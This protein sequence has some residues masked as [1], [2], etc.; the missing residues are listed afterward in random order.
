MV[1]DRDNINDINMIAKCMGQRARVHLKVDTGMGRFGCSPEEAPDLA[2]FAHRLEWVELEG[3]AT[4]FPRSDEGPVGFTMHQINLFKRVISEVSERGAGYKFIHAAN[5]GALL[6]RV[7]Q[8]PC[9][10]VRTGL[11]LYGYAPS[12][13]LFDSRLRPA[14]EV[15]TRVIQV[16][17][18]RKGTPVG[19]ATPSMP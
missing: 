1:F 2:E 5:S 19:Y 6:S 18:I 11:M 17:K 13:V 12:R 10:M 8:S 7:P 14:M 3:I 4:H 15:V 16:K 9:N